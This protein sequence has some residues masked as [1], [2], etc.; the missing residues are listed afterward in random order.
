MI[1]SK[2]SAEICFPFSL[3]LFFFFFYAEQLSGGKWI[4]LN[5]HAPVTMA[6]LSKSD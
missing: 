3:A 4:F 1:S 5:V 2:Q 6:A